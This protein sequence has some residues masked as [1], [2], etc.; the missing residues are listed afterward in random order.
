MTRCFLSWCVGPARHAEAPLAAGVEAVR[1][2]FAA[3]HAAGVEGEHAIAA[4][5]AE[6]RPVTED[7]GAVRVA[8]MGQLEPRVKI[9]R[10]GAGFALVLERHAPVGLAEAHPRHRVDDDPCAFHAVQ[11]VVPAVR[12]VAVQVF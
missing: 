3:P 7:H 9:W 1:G 10:L 4:Q 8:S 6:R 5:E 11:I 2:E 12:F